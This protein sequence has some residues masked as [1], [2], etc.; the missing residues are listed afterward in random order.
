MPANYLY[1]AMG[2]G[3]WIDILQQQFAATT[4]WE[5]IAVIAGVIQVFLARA[6]SV[7]TYPAGIISTAI[8]IYL[9]ATVGLYAESSLNVYYL[10]MSIY[11]WVHWLRKKSESELPIT[12]ANTSEWMIAVAIILIGWLAMWQVLDR[13]TDSNVPLI[14]AWVSASAWAGM[15]LL[16]RRKIENWLVLNLS[17]LFAMPL[18]VYKGMYLTSLLTLIL[19]IVAI[20]GF[21]EWRRLYKQQKQS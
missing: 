3:H 18:L 13:Y 14:D 21:I 1:C 11:G 5:W 4:P 6:N 17:N 2:S 19:F 12:H 15:W 8:Y 7:W 10:I 20:F 9:M 16:A